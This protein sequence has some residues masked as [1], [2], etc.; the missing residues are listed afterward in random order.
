MAKASKIANK[1]T[2]E[3]NQ[4]PQPGEPLD[5]ALKKSPEGFDFWITIES[6]NNLR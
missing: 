2:S 4:L 6:G 3:D 5:V 1:F